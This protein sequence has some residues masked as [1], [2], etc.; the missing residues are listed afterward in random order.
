MRN[1]D[2]NQNFSQKGDVVMEEC[3]TSPGKKAW[4]IF[5]IEATSFPTWVTIYALPQTLYNLRE[6][7]RK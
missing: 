1:T 2:V 4:K 6:G 7:L 3:E 5:A